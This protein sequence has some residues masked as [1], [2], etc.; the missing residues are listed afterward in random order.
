VDC[1]DGTREWHRACR[2]NGEE[3][4]ASR[5]NPFAANG[6]LRPI[7]MD[8]VASPWRHEDIRS[9]PGVSRSAPPAPMR[10]PRSCS[11]LGQASP[12]PN[13][14]PECVPATPT[15]SRNIVD[16]L[17]TADEDGHPHVAA[18]HALQS[19]SPRRPA[20]FSSPSGPGPAEE[21]PLPTTRTEA[22]HRE[23]RMRVFL[24]P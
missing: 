19:A 11:W 17:A 5:S 14:R 23:K 6:A 9:S 3:I 8:T 21:V 18:L 13:W 2:S 10:Q 24:T 7:K 15:I 20:L 4:T 12:K 1:C 16:W 22:I